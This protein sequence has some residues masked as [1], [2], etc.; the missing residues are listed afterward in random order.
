M[1]YFAF[2]QYF[3]TTVILQVFSY[4]PCCL[5]PLASLKKAALCLNQTYLFD[6]L[7]TSDY[8][9]TSTSFDKARYFESLLE[10]EE[11]GSYTY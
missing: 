3:L 2:F 11:T 10:S 8:L 5:K 6:K 1:D 9:P 7:D 4:R